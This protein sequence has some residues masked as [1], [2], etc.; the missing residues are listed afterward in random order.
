LVSSIAIALCVLASVQGAAQ[1]CKFIP[2]D[3]GGKNHIIIDDEVYFYTTLEKSKELQKRYRKYPLVVEEN[4]ALEK[5]A[6]ILNGI[7]DIQ[8]DTIVR[9]GDEIE[10]AHEMFKRKPEPVEEWYENPDVT[11]V[12]G[13]GFTAA[14]FFFWKWAEGRSQD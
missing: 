8:A 6:L 1:E 2:E 7:V 14:S 4:E 3:E 5:K 13:A 11:F 9:Q 10:F 12:M